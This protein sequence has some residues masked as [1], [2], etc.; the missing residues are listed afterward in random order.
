MQIVFYTPPTF[1]NDRASTYIPHL[2][3]HCVGTKSAIGLEDYFSFHLPIKA[4]FLVSHAIY[5]M[6]DYDRN[7]NHLYRL[8]QVLS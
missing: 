5:T 4:E 6:A 2:V 1:H 8:C 7:E 3:E